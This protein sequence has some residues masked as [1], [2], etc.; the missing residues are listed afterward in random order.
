MVL[1][2]YSFFF[3]FHKVVYFAVWLYFWNQASP[4]WLT[5]SF[6]STN[7]G[8]MYLPVYLTVMLF[9]ILAYFLEP[10]VPRCLSFDPHPPTCLRSLF[11]TLVVEWC[12]WRAQVTILICSHFY[13]MPFSSLLSLV[14]ISW[15]FSVFMWVPFAI[16]MSYSPNTTPWWLRWVGQWTCAVYHLS[17][18]QQMVNMGTLTISSQREAWLSVEFRWVYGSWNDGHSLCSRFSSNSG[19]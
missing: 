17:S 11:T 13:K 3:S 7:D 1:F 15:I 18:C 16:W 10:T 8:C 9:T 4:H 5:C 6:P 12:T 14:S 2:F 19:S